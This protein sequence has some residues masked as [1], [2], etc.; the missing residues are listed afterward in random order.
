MS[1]ILELASQLRAKNVAEL[2]Q[3][4]ENSL[5]HGHGCDDYFDLSRVLL[6][7][8]ELEP[9]I[10]ALPASELEALRNEK[11]T[12]HLRSQNL[13]TKT[14]LP[15]AA[16]LGRELEIAKYKP[17]N[18]HGSYLTAYESLICITELLFACERHWLDVIRAGIRSQDAKEIALKLKIAP[19][20]VQRIFQ[21]AL[22]A[23][24]IGQNESRW[25]ATTLGMEW[26]ELERSQAWL[27]LA[28]SCWDLP[29]L[30]VHEGP[31]TEQ[32]STA[33]PLAN[34]ATIKLL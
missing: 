15:E 33:Y 27:M 6:S 31:L 5:G 25:V 9:K 2:S 1:S 17:A 20:D 19:K 21:L 11:T 7:R 14:A 18:R 26:L 22:E 3:T 30:K 29:A 13:A 32:I 8:R 28:K 34:L 4:L 10:R 16:S 24:L 12:A 23:G